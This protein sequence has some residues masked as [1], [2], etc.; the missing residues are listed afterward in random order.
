MNFVN[1]LENWA[2]VFVEMIIPVVSFIITYRQYVLQKNEISTQ[3]QYSETVN[4]TQIGHT[5]E[6]KI[7]VNTNKES[8]EYYYKQNQ[9][10]KAQQKKL[11]FET[12]STII[13]KA[14]VLI[15]F[16]TGAIILVNNYS[17]DFASK[18]GFMTKLQEFDMSIM[19]A[20]Q[21][22]GQLTL[23]LVFGLSIVMIF[24]TLLFSTKRISVQ[25]MLTWFNLIL[26]NIGVFLTLSIFKTNN[27]GEEFLKLINKTPQPEENITINS[28]IEITPPI[29]MSI[30][31]AASFIVA[32]NLLKMV[33]IKE[34]YFSIKTKYTFVIATLLLFA[35]PSVF[36]LSI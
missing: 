28:L 16:I 31:I 29:L 2:T 26:I 36:Q 25:N 30:L 7:N 5:N 35:I 15:L 3:K 8:E 10:K 12:F 27:L 6:M 32:I 19:N 14:F 13:E 4:Y 20:F 18:K 9:M 24:K 22:I 17:P 1:Q 23:H 21:S 33:L 34:S 11:K